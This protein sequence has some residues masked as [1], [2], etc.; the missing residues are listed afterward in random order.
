MASTAVIHTSANQR[1]FSVKNAKT[2]NTANIPKIKKN[3]VDGK[4]CL[5]STRR[6]IA[7][8]QDTYAV[9]TKTVNQ[10]PLTTNEGFSSAMY[11]FKSIL[12]HKE[13]N[14]DTTSIANIPTTIPIIRFKYP[15]P[16]YICL[17]Q[18]K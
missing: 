7:S 15:T 13:H 11:H 3:I 1:F 4:K 8:T 5:Y 12:K 2:K 16:K 9:D 10:P 18:V 6:D 17:A 14:P